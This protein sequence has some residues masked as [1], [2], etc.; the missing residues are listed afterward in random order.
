MTNICFSRSNIKMVLYATLFLSTIVY[1]IKANTKI[2][3]FRIGGTERGTSE[4]TRVAVELQ[5]L[6][7]TNREHHRLGSDHQE[8]QSSDRRTEWKWAITRWERGSSHHI[9][10]LWGH[11]TSQPE[12][13]G[14]QK[15]NNKYRALISEP[16]GNHK[17]IVT[18]SGFC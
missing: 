5:Q 2:W 11:N 13:G 18:K 12:L 8:V 1:C 3:Y 4:S 10:Q 14:K 9:C 16:S 17:E 15:I 7:H 6:C